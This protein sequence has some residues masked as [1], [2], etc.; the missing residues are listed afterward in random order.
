MIWNTI[1]LMER[2]DSFETQHI[3]DFDHKTSVYTKSE[4]EINF[5]NAKR[6]IIREKKHAKCT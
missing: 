2:W 6:E 1:I 4:S 5:Y 3:F